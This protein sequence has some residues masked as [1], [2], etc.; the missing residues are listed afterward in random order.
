[1]VWTELLSRS[2]LSGT[3][4]ARRDLPLMVYQTRLA[5]SL[6]VVALTIWSLEGRQSDVQLSLT[7][8]EIAAAIEW[9][10]TARPEGYTL[11]TS[12]GVRVGAVFTPYLRVALAS[13]VA[14]ESN[15]PF[16]PEDVTPQLIDPVGPESGGRAVVYIAMRVD[17]IESPADPQAFPDVRLLHDPFDNASTAIT[18][19]GGR[20]IGQG[21]RIGPRYLQYGLESMA[22]YSTASFQREQL[23]AGMG[24]ELF[25]RAH[26]RR[27]ERAPRRSLPLQICLLGGEPGG[28]TSRCSRRAAPM[29]CQD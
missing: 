13:R 21:R 11:R 28:L 27:W 8:D 19:M 14:A 4:L 9:G 3:E 29:M 10:R 6:V 5:L 16:A 17:G 15:Q 26:G 18:S 2:P 7:R 20:R 25:D 24:V 22:V 12:A 23:R 1:M